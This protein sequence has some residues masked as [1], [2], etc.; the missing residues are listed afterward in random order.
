MPA[1]DLEPVDGEIAPLNREM[2]QPTSKVGRY[3]L[4][5][6]EYNR[7]EIYIRVCKA[8]AGENMTVTSKYHIFMSKA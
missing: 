3:R 2:R 1:V 8:I 6:Y 5:E 4:F 7:I